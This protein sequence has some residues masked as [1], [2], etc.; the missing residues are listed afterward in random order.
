M[1]ADTVQKERELLLKVLGTARSY[2]VDILDADQ[3]ITAK[4]QEIEAYKKWGEERKNKSAYR[5]LS[6][7]VVACV[8]LFIVG[9][10]LNFFILSAIFRDFNSFVYDIDITLRIGMVSLLGV[11]FCIVY[12]L[13][14]DIR[15]RK[16]ASKFAVEWETTSK[17]KLDGLNAQLQELNTYRKELAQE[18]AAATLSLLPPRYTYLEA[19]DFFIDVIVNLRADSMKEAVNL[20]E[21]HLHRQR[22]EAAQNKLA[23][24]QTQ[25]LQLQQENQA[26][27]NSISQSSLSASSSVQRVEADVQTL[28]SLAMIQYLKK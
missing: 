6:T 15:A 19:I 11:A 4:S 9:F 5:N 23:E 26:I 18:K 27:L 22:M 3:R 1:T 12:L 10:A 20:Y 2:I 17:Q 14:R 8:L 21:E 24:Q 25:M 28:E 7:D 13:Y 16:E